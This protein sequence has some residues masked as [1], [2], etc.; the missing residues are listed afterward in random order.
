MAV[1]AQLVLAPRGREAIELARVPWATGGTWVAEHPRAGSWARR[2]SWGLQGR[3][4]SSV[5]R[6][7]VEGDLDRADVGREICL[8]RVRRWARKG[9][10]LS[11]DAP[12]LAFVSFEDCKLEDAAEERMIAGPQTQQRPR[13]MEELR[14]DL[15]A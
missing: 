15:S 2:R 12:L 3:A 7:G 14:L 13:R 10:Y 11:Y 9:P 5:G 1:K 8:F 6:V 4:C